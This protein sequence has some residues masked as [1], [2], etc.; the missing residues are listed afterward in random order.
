MNMDRAVAAAL[1]SSHTLYCPVPA[2][3]AASH[4]LANRPASIRGL[5]IGFLGN[6]KPNCDVLLHTTE[7]EVMKLGAA[8]TLYREKS[9]CSLG[10]ELNI[11]DE[12]AARCNVAVVALGD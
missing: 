8:S 7:G 3:E 10:A 4:A 1:E 6:L 5:K 12:I 2:G 11:L 9:S